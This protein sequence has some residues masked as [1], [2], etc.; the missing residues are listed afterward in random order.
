MQKSLKG[1]RTKRRLANALRELLRTKPLEKIRI[2]DLTDR[3][4][5]HRQTFYYHFDDIYALFA[6]CVQ[7]DAETLPAR[8]S[9]FPSWQKALCDLL[10]YTAENRGCFMAVL[11][12]MPPAERKGFFDR[13]LN[14]ILEKFLHGCSG[15]Q[16]GGDVSQDYLQS[17]SIMLFT[18]LE[19]WIRE[20]PGQSPEE[21]VQFLEKLTNSR[22]L[23]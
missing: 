13:L 6:W 17:I 16:V 23:A 10:E 4:D 18:L 1:Y 5:I 7:Q 12:H 3:C 14:A 22:A 2:H 20:T 15:G 9:Q 11:D 8:L 19:K 21:A